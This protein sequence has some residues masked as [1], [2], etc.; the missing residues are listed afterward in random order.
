MSSTRKIE[1]P[2]SIIVP[3]YNR[4]SLLRDALKSIAEQTYTDYEVLVIQN[5]PFHTAKA[6]V[7]E[8]QTSIP[9]I[10]YH[11]LDRASAANARNIGI[12]EARG[13]YIAVLEDDDQW[14]SEKLEKQVELI[15]SDPQIGLVSAPSIELNLVQQQ[16][17]K[18]RPLAKRECNYSEMIRLENVQIISSLS[19]TLFRK[20]AALEVGLFDER[21]KISSDVD[22]YIRLSKKYKIVTMD[23]PLFYY[24]VHEQ[25]ASSNLMAGCEDMV[26][27]LERESEIQSNEIHLEIKKAISIYLDKIYSYATDA[28]EAMKYKQAFAG[29]RFVI[30]HNPWFGKRIRWGQEKN[31]LYKLLRPYL[32]FLYCCLQLILGQGGR[33]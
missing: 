9:G 20:D 17:G 5:G 3:T 33:P 23:Q 15:E 19:G 12:S 28:L 16:L 6:V 22:F 30:S 13:E 24:G 10:R 4:T 26:H 27:I 25:N 14:F 8:F 1:P 11:H 31:I 21:Y 29:Y 32:A 7:E 2:V 18:R